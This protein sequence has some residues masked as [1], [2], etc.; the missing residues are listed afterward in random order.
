[1]APQQTGQIRSELAVSRDEIVCDLRNRREPRNFFIQ[2]ERP[3]MATAGQGAKDRLSCT[4]NFAIWRNENDRVLELARRDF[5][6]LRRYFLRR[7]VLDPVSS[8]LT[9]TL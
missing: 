2:R 3:P 4:I 5:W 9:P 6:K 8:F 1:M 7:F